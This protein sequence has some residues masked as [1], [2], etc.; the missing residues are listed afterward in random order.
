MTSR[1]KRGDR[2]QH[3]PAQPLSP[4]AGGRGSA[5]I[6]VRTRCRQVL[7]R[8]AATAR[9]RRRAR[10]SPSTASSSASCCRH[11]SHASRCAWRD[12]VERP[13]RRRRSSSSEVRCVMVR[14]RGASSSWPARERS[15]PWSRR[16]S[17]RGCRRSA[18]ATGRDTSAGSAWRAASSAARRSPCGP[19]PR[20]LRAAAP[21]ARPRC[22]CPRSGR[23][24]SI[25]SVAGVLALTRLRQTF[26]AMR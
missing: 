3:R 12:G 10:A 16:P 5:S 26:T 13:A 19:R 21:T 9:A 18:G 24:T 22:A 6:A 23:S 14:S 2:R 8:T 15:W 25:G 11:D 20:A 4:A 7:P 1:A 17:C